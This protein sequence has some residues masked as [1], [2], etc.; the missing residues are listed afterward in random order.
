VVRVTLKE[1][2]AVDWQRLERHLFTSS[3]CGACGKTS[4]A[5]LQTASAPALPSDGPRVE[6]AVLHLLSERLRQHQMVFD[7]TRG[8]HASALFDA[9][10]QL[11]AVREDV[12][13]HNAL[14]KLIG[15][16]LLAGR[17]PLSDR[18]LFV[19]GRASF[20]LVQKA[21]MAGIPILAAVG[22]PSSLAVD[23]ARDS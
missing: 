12:G 2:L 9:A 14:D 11:L 15:A 16:E 10:G 4:L 23:L 22:A 13:R 19:S 1:D 20:E 18:I 7:H 17:L 3:S 6:A 21:L 8:L 5:A